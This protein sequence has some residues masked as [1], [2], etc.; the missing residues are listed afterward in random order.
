MTQKNIDK[1]VEL[2]NLTGKF[3]GRL[4]VLERAGS[5]KQG[6][7]LWVCKCACGQ[8]AVVRSDSL[9]S[10]H[11]KSC[12]CL[13]I[14]KSTTHGQADTRLYRVWRNMLARCG[15]PKNL[16]YKDY[17]ARGITICSEWTKFEPFYSWAMANG[18]T[19]ELTI[20]RLNNDK[21]YSPRNCR[22]ATM[23]EQ[24]A[25]G[26]HRMRA[27][28]KTGVVGVSFH[29]STQKYQAQIKNKKV[30]T[31]IGSFPTLALAAE[32]RKKAEKELNAS[33]STSSP[34][35]KPLSNLSK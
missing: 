25:V 4:T 3:F 1:R 12:G 29:K 17:G 30:F 2:V 31:Y 28:N 27:D 19:D 34:K 7:S 32:A 11:T 15:N 16:F 33:I 6:A 9:Q 14:E 35:P 8:E 13:Q 5:N 26:K 10:E 21:G 18:Y 23:Q 22:W 24:N 20:D